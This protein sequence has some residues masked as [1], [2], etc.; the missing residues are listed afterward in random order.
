MFIVNCEVYPFDVLVYFGEDGKPLYKELKKY[1]SKSEIKN[2]KNLDFKRGK[3]I[4]FDKGQTLLWLRKKPISIQ[5]IPVLNHEIFHCT[6]FILEKVGIPYSETTEEA[7][8]YLIE[9]LSKKIYNQLEITF[10]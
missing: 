9:F 6:C 3:T 1:L 4:M 2:L 7:Y 10:S 5:D 8:A